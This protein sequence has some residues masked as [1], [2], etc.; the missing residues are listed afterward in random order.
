MDEDGDGEVSL[1][2]FRKWRDMR[3]ADVDHDG[4]V[5]EEEIAA[6]AETRK[7][8]FEDAKAEGY[9]VH[10]LEH[11]PD[12]EN[13]LTPTRSKLWIG[14]KLAASKIKEDTTKP[15]P[16]NTDETTRTPAPPRTRPQTARLADTQRAAIPPRQGSFRFRNA[17]PVTAY[18][19]RPSLSPF[20]SEW[21]A[22]P[23][24]ARTGASDIYRCREK[25][26][27]G[28]PLTPRMPPNF[29]SS[30]T[31]RWTRARTC[32]SGFRVHHKTSYD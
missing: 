22:R 27:G 7:K 11:S 1:E 25:R 32:Q 6:F 2:E 15:H 19:A 21:N 16:P 3:A 26:T 13:V 31:S 20:S 9:V 17:R 28:D 29:T 23:R 30:I 14:D 18:T 4:Q 10:E 5:T 8:R 12:K 24:S